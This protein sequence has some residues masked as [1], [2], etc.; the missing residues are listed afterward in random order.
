MKFHNNGGEELEER[1][2]DDSLSDQ[3]QFSSYKGT[4]RKKYS[5]SDARRDRNVGKKQTIN[6]KEKKIPGRVRGMFEWVS[7]IVSQC[8]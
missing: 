8:I 5:I 1:T 3:E 6:D 4:K 7:H 2:S